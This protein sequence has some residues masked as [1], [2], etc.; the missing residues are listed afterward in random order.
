MFGTGGVMDKFFNQ[1]LAAHADTSR[2]EWTWRQGSAVTSLLSPGTL[3]EFQRAND[4]R[5]AF[6]QTGGNQPM[7]SLAFLPPFVSGATVK[8]DAGGNVVASPAGS[9]GGFFSRPAPPPAPNSIAAI[10]VQWPGASPR[11]AVSV[12]IDRDG[13]ASV[14]DKTGPWSLF[15]L[16]EAGSL[17]VRAE[18]AS[19]TF[20]VGGQELRY[21]ITS[22]SI[23]NPLD[24][25]VVREFR[26]PTGI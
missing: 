23:Q 16:L 17:Q 15:R 5:N 22:S 24:L 26:C 7:V 11:T 8:F 4:I 1:Y 25:R 18:T 10:T 13:S 6:F 14:L 21:Q 20:I 2:R 3:R 19:A 12:A 9:T